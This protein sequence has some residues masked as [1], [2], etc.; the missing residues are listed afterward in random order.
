MKNKTEVNQIAV[1]ERVIAVL[2]AIQTTPVAST[3]EL[4]EQ[5][6]PDLS[7]RSA[8]RYLKGLE[9]AGYVRRVLCGN[10]GDA[11]YFLTEK[12]KQLFGVKG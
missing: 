12:S 9:R 11:R 4:R 3:S 6:L 8:Q 7:L 1:F 2:Q 5:V 10:C